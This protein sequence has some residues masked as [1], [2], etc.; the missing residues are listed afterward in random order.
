MTL[1]VSA[2]NTTGKSHQRNAIPTMSSGTGRRIQIEKLKITLSYFKWLRKWHQVFQSPGN[3]DARE[4]GASE[5]QQEVGQCFRA[6]PPPP[7]SMP[8]DAITTITNDCHSRC[9]CAGATI[10]LVRRGVSTTSL[11]LETVDRMSEP[12]QARPRKQ[13]VL[14]P[15]FAVFAAAFAGAFAVSFFLDDAIG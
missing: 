5:L 13:C 9:E 7:F 2:Q 3:G 11:I 4:A 15:C 8:H 1:P 6:A 10:S 12:S 14:E